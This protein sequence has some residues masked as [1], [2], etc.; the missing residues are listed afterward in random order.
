MRCLLAALAMVIATIAHGAVDDHVHLGVASCATGVCHGKLSPQTDSN[1]WLN[2]YRV[3]SAEDRHARA[4]LTLGSAESKAMAA[5]LGIASAQTAKI[6]LDCHADNVPADK[7]GRKFQISDGIACEACHGGAQLWIESH[8]EPGVTHADNIARGLYPSED[9]GER[10]E[11]CLNCHMGAADRYATHVIMG[12]GHPRLSFEL[13]AFST[14]QPAHFD[15]D[16]DYRRRKGDVTGFRLWLTGQV[17]GAQRMLSLQA[18][19][20]LDAPVGLF[21]ELALYDCQSCHHAMDDVRLVTTGAG[22]GIKPGTLRLNDDH[23]RVLAVVA[24]VIDAEGR[25]E[26]AT[27]SQALIRAGQTSV[28]AVR[29]AAADLDRWIGARR[30]AWSKRAFGRDEVVAVRRALV[31]AAAG[32][33][34]S[35]YGSAEQVYLAVDSLNIALGDGGAMRQAVDEL[36]AA[37]ENDQ[38]YRPSRFTAAA[39][40][41]LS[42]L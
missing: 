24:G 36:Y 15:V 2:E 5:K 28:A 26:L 20:W 4:Y 21:P 23:L 16:E 3:W 34:L 10:A 41:L 25:A 17:V 7:R 27:R 13:D 31:A 37:V 12:A 33:D 39:R 29:T 32:G 30:S 18:S 22:P 11:L 14:N 19:A 8:T 40:A 38:T 9:P 42:R 35:D 1:V 6:C